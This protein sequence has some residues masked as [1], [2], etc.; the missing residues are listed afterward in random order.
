MATKGIIAFLADKQETSN[1]F[2]IGNVKIQITEG[3]EWDAAN[4]NNAVP[5]FAQNIMP[6]RTI[7][8]APQI[9]N[10]G[11]NPAYVYMKVYVP[12]YEGE[13]MFSYTVTPNNGWTKRTEVF[14]TNDNKYNV[15]VYEYDTTLNPN[16][17]TP[18]IFESVTLAEFSAEDIKNRGNTNTKVIIKG[19]AIQS[20]N[21]ISKAS[22]E[23]ITQMTSET[24]EEE[25]LVAHISTADITTATLGQYVNLG[26]NLLGKNNT[27][28]ADWRVFSKDENGA[29]LILA[30]YLP[31]GEG[32]TGASVVSSVGL[33]TSGTYGVKSTV[34]REDLVSKLNGDWSG[35]LAG[36]DVTG[37]TVKGAVS[38]NQWK[39]S[40]NANDVDT[41]LYTKYENPVSGKTYDGWYIG[42]APDP[43]TKTFN[44]ASDKGYDNTL[45]FPHKSG[46]SYYYGYWLA[47]PSAY[48]D[49]HV[50]SVY[51]YGP[52]Y[53]RDFYDGHYG[54]RP[55]VY[56]PS[57]ISFNTSGEVWTIAQ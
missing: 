49:G 19:F 37:L 25:G 11:V 36:S 44:L 28:E 14:H 2:T 39:D 54:V 46:V 15:Y 43:T 13:E 3:A 30:D 18:A 4:A 7:P 16:G 27:T 52:V 24:G 38:L 35:L 41:T 20:E 22:N 1:V 21:G 31:V 9:K 40:W 34:S 47:S 53:G 5:A 17:I 51:S 55:A 50:M 29:W 23:M 57:N 48:K 8:K 10:I 6:G 45:Y 56:L 26:T 12:L 42:N 33:T 32:T